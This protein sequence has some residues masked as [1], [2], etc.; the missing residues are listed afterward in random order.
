MPL[1]KSLKEVTRAYTWGTFFST[2]NSSF[3]LFGFI[4]TKDATPSCAEGK[5]LSITKADENTRNY[6]PF[7]MKVVSRTWTGLHSQEYPKRGPPLSPG[8]RAA[9]SPLSVLKREQICWSAK[10]VQC[11]VLQSSLLTR[12][13][14]NTERGKI[15]KSFRNLFA[16]N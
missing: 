7:Q 8:A 12:V 1:M 14:Y 11:C 2:Q 13:A 15:S 9:S 3:V 16:R 6:K 4:W 10:F 5:V